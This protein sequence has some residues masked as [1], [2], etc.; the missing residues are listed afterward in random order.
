MQ[1]TGI[2][3]VRFGKVVTPKKSQTTDK[4]KATIARNLLVKLDQ[5]IANDARVLLKMKMRG[6][7]TTRLESL[8]ENLFKEAVV[9]RESFPISGNRI[10][11]LFNSKVQNLSTTINFF[12][13]QCQLELN[14]H[15]K[16]KVR[17][18]R[19]LKCLIDDMR[20]FVMQFKMN[21]YSVEVELGTNGQ[22]LPPSQEHIP[23]RKTDLNRKNYFYALLASYKNPS[24]K[25]IKFPRHKTIEYLM[26]QAGYKFPDRTYRLYKTQIK[27][28]TFDHFV[29]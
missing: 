6:I 5:V 8:I 20:H 14:G 18:W 7:F 11:K 9:I 24:G 13:S 27:N 4:S 16:F 17:I 29:Q 25:I 19:T 1:T 23:Y 12:E 2:T 3:R 22:I 26:E 10:P 15:I 21:Y 28:G